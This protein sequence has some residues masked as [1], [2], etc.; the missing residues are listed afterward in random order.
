[1]EETLS[2]NVA[3]D[4]R[5]LQQGL[6]LRC[7]DKATSL[8]RIVEGLDPRA[9]TSPEEQVLAPIVNHE[10]EHAVEIVQ[11]GGAFFFIQP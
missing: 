9:V 1:M 2:V 5:K 10:D 4:E 8:L 7:A 3:R 11:K 6:Q